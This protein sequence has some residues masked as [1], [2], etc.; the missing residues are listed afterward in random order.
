MNSFS[1]KDVISGL[2]FLISLVF[3]LWQPDRSNFIWLISSYSLSFLSYL[4]LVR[5]DYKT[6]KTV[7]VILGI[8]FC[9]VFKPNLSNDYFR[10]LW[11]GEMLTK[12]IN[13]YEHIPDKLI[14]N[15][16]FSES[17]YYVDLHR[18]MGE[19]S[20]RHYSC[21]PSINQLYFYLPALTSNNIGVNLFVMRIMILLT[22]LM[23]IFYLKKI[24]HL[25]GLDS[26]RIWI[27]VLNPLFII[28]TFG[29]VHFEAVMMSF[30]LAGIYFL[31]KS[32][33]IL[34][35]FL[36]ATAIQVKLIPLMVLPFFLRMIGLKRSV[37]FYSA[38]FIGTAL[39][40]ALFLRIDNY[41]LFSESLSLYF[42]SFEFNSFVV[43]PISELGKHLFDWYDLRIFTSLFSQITVISIA[44]LALY[45]KRSTWE[46]LL[47]KI[48]WGLV[49]YFLLTST[50][51]PWYL[52][53]VLTLSV[54]TS[55]TFVVIWTFVVFFSY[56]FY[57]HFD[58]HDLVYRLMV[59]SSYLIVL[60]CAVYELRYQ[61]SAL[62]FLKLTDQ[63]QPVSSE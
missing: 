19:L 14:T 41:L 31:M 21:Y 63:R 58:Y 36:L 51:H 15:E 54:L 12:G 46:E 37:L 57:S 38:T 27:L 43:Y 24:L 9:F 30:V 44:I 45:G 13:P 62:P 11:D 32:K 17:S 18:G 23:G 1:W 53:T 5:S 33:D 48:M 4:L 8:A 29:N 34:S 3:I 6:V 7:L 61:K 52:I 25:L 59:G 49:I 16:T 35:G 56:Q 20:A 39:L 26:R 40:A 50:L 60:G 22:V 2:V 42:N 10:F 47:I 55:Y 28:E